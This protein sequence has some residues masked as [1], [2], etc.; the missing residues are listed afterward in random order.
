MNWTLEVVVVPVSDVDRA[1][2]FYAERLGF[3]V[4]HDT[5]VGDDVHVVQLTPPG[6]GCSIVVGKGL[7]DM[8]PGS[9]RGLQ[10]VVSDL[11]AARAQ[12]VERGVEVSEIQVLGKSPNPEPDPLDNVGFVFFNDPDGNSWAVQQIS[13]RG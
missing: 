1:K 11:H 12:L 4:D 5:K 3:T 10:L 6:S 7:T 9:L 8:A 13:A 2:A